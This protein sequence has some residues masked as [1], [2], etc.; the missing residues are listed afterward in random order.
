MADTIRTE[1]ALD[2]LLATNGTGA[3]SAQ[4]LRDA[5]DS[6]HPENIT[7]VRFAGS[8]SAT[9]QLDAVGSDTYFVP[10]TTGL[11]V[12]GLIWYRVSAVLGESSN[13][14]FEEDLD[15]EGITTKVAIPVGAACLL[16]YLPSVA[17][18]T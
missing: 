3:I 5:I 8:G 14:V 1:S 9:I 16:S 18:P 7:H 13:F 12:D 6:C 10:G 11:C 4:D 17:D 15:A 2:T